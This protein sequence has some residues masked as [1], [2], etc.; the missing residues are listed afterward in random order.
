MHLKKYFIYVGTVVYLLFVIFFFYYFF[1]SPKFLIQTDVTSFLT[2]AKIIKEGR[3]TDLYNLDVQLEYQNSVIFPEYKK[4]LLPF[5]NFP[6]TAVVYIPLLN[7]GLQNSYIAVFITNVLLLTV[8]TLL[9]LRTFPGL[10]KK[11]LFYFLPFFFWPSVNNLIVGQY[12]PVILLIFLWI[13][14]SIRDKKNI[15]SGFATSFLVL[16]PQY[17]LFTPFAFKMS[18]NKTDYMKGFL[19]GILLFV[20]INVCITRGNLTP[21]SDYPD[22]LLTTESSSFGSRPYQMFT[23]YGLEKQIMPKL[24]EGLLLAYNFVG[25][26]AILIYIIFKK[27]TKHLETY[28]S[29]G[30]VAALLFSIHALTH[31]L[32]VLLLPI[33]FLFNEKNSNGYLMAILIAAPFLNL[34]LSGKLALFLSISILLLFILYLNKILRN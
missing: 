8:F 12:T 16:K 21:F 6:I 3:V 25:Y 29:F 28:F 23:L 9:V 31:D 14:R 30:I 26:L 15:V 11:V 34:L 10:K 5:R 20:L 22:F 32:L 4:F 17:L 24:K 1:H 13:Y 18:N 7:L 2:G 27:T 33:Y 19:I